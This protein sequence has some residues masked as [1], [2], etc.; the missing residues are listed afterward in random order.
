MA[1]LQVENLSFT[2][3]NQA[4]PTLDG[5][6]FSVERGQ[7]VLLCGSSGSGKS[8]LLRQLK[9]ALRPHGNLSGQLLLDAA[10]LDALS[11]RA[12][13]ESIG[14]VLQSPENQ[15]VTDTVWRELAFGL[16]R[17]GYDSH[18]IRLRVAEMAGF[19]GI[20]HL[21][22]RK[23]A[24]LSGGQLQILNLAAAMTLSP[25]LLLLDEPTA[26]L[27]PL[28]ATDFLTMLRRINQELGTTIFLSEHRLEELFP[29]ADK[30]IFLEN[31]RLFCQGLPEEVGRT[32]L[33]QNHPMAQ[34]LPAATQL[35][36]KCGR[37]GAC[38][39]TVQ[40]GQRWLESFTQN[41]PLQPLLPLRQQPKQTTVLTG[42]KLWF[43]Y[44]ADQPL[45]KGLSIQLKQ[46]ELLA[47]LGA[48][49]AGKSTLLKL[50]TGLEKSHRGGV[51]T[52]AQLGLLPQAPQ[53]LFLKKTLR[54]DLA[55]SLRLAPF[56]SN[57][58]EDA[59][60]QVI[61]LCHLG[62]LLERH[63]FDLS[64][65][66]QQRA[67][68]AKLLLWNPQVLLLDEPTKGLDAQFKAELAEIFSA[69]QRQ[70]VSILMASHD[71]EFCAR[72]ASRC[73]LLFD[74]TLVSEGAPSNFF[75]QNRFYTTAA[76]RIA[77]R[78]LPELVT[79]DELL[80]VCGAESL[81]P[82]AVSVQP[83]L[84][85]PVTPVVS[86]LLPA[87]EPSSLRSSSLSPSHFAALIVLFLVPLTVLTGRFLLNDN[88]YFAISMLIVLELL[89][90]PFLLFE[91]RRP[92][93]R[94]LAVLAVL[95]AL[96]VAGRAIT[97]FFPQFKPV[98]ALSI[99]AGVGLG[100]ASGF[101]VGAVSMLLSNM[102]L[103]QGPW[104]PWQM[105]AM[106]FVGFL[107]GFLFH[108]R[109]KM[110]L[111]PIYGFVATLGLYGTIMNLFS[112]LS[113]HRTLTPGVALAYMGAGLPADLTHGLSTALLLLFLGPA[114]GEIFKRIRE[115]YGI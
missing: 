107:G 36:G 110:W 80:Y 99:L 83:P 49:G 29:L 112:A 93:A 47:L 94:E 114:M 65:G 92:Q 25:A 105:F 54:E 104:T 6:S 69:L 42:E 60:A 22:E 100:P 98:A 23:L 68:L 32:L 9:S 16:E 101:L 74:G 87:S 89:L 115:K 11:Q 21:F 55:D 71:V 111:L 108:K 113:W 41:Q 34:A 67:A 95:C 57:S 4:H 18:T 13:S 35:W 14:L 102:L 77:R 12:Q 73:A 109:K 8:T 24:T 38:P 31:G 48:N 15:V 106:G 33:E 3:P 66:E 51:C 76:S 39:L 70:G 43:G 5:L 91:E 17:L 59:L 90:P 84:S 53:A 88:Y 96:G 10:P 27:D 37:Q 82:E 1:F 19:F 58:P 20:T 28:A 103:V 7:F 26:M 63:P 61:G 78:Y 97:P 52:D 30:V 75:P 79:L 62:G 45:L 50:L 85:A 46:G 86:T 44:E 40:E 64:A 81:P 56:G 72:Y 2:Y